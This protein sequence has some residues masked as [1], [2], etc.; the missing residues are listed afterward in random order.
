M[1]NLLFPEG[2][3]VVGASSA[4]SGSVTIKPHSSCRWF[5]LDISISSAA[6]VTVG[7]RL[8]DSS[9]APQVFKPIVGA[10]PAELAAITTSRLVNFLSADE[11]EIAWTG[12]DGVLTILASD[13]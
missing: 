10:A 7:G 9:I 2:K 3:I 1:P 6:S 8:L 13:Y 11:L 4:S 5:M 12:N